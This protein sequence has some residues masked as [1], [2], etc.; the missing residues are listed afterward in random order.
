MT[1][2]FYTNEPMDVE[3][4]LKALHA[5]ARKLSR[6]ERTNI[7]DVLIRINPFGMV[8]CSLRGTN[9]EADISTNSFRELTELISALLDPMGQPS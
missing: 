1:K 4:N 9:Y 7:N 8:R 3:R 2:P 6:M 5:K